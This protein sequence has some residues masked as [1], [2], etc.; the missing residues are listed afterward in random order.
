MT[1]FK[2]NTF[3]YIIRKYLNLFWPIL[4][5]CFIWPVIIYFNLNNIYNILLL[6][7]DFI[8]P[9]RSEFYI[10]V[11]PILLNLIKILKESIPEP[12]DEFF[13]VDIPEIIRPKPISIYDPRHPDKIPP[14]W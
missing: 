1:L 11:Y 9:I 2:N 13:I 7:W 3:I 8:W 10:R 12:F 4:I 5:D 14:M 6:I